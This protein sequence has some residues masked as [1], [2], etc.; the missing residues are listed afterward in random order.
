MP[1]VDTGDNNAHNRNEVRENSVLYLL[2]Y[3]AA[4]GA[5][6][7][8]VRDIHNPATWV[9]LLLGGMVASLLMFGV[10]EHATGT[11]QRS[12]EQE[13]DVQTEE[14]NENDND[15]DFVQPRKRKRRRRIQSKLSDGE[16]EVPASDDAIETAPNHENVKPKAP[17]K[18]RCGGDHM[19]SGTE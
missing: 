16:D 8:G 6:F 11:R 4:M 12:D 2:H 1:P 5:T 13:Q 18:K 10:I 15:S 7:D 17:G 3:L 9:A 19:W 14:E